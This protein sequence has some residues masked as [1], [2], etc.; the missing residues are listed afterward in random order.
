MAPK[1]EKQFFKKST[2]HMKPHSALSEKFK[3]LYYDHVSGSCGSSSDHI[4]PTLKHPSSSVLDEGN[5]SGSLLF[6]E[7]SIPINPCSFD[8]NPLFV[9]KSLC[10]L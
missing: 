4:S 1:K 10:D 6:V 2:T 8:T 3:P 7:D 9:Y 5:I